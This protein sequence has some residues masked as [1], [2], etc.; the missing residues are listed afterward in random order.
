MNCAGWVGQLTTDRAYDTYAI[1]G[2]LGSGKTTG[3]GVAFFARVLTNP[4]VKQFWV[5]AP[6]YAKVDDT[7]LPTACFVLSNWFGLKLD[8]HFKIR[9]TKPACLTILAT[10]QEI[11]FHSGDRPYA[12]VSATIGGYWISE[13]GIQ[14]RAVFE[15]C[16]DRARDKKIDKVFGFIEGTPEGSN[17]YSDEFNIEGTDE[18]K[19]Y[20][21]FIIK[22]YDNIK[23]LAD[24]YIERLKR[25][26]SYSPAKILSYLYGQFANFTTGNV[27]AQYNESKNVLNEDY[28]PSPMRCVDLCFDFNATPLC[29][30]CWQ[31]T[32]VFI[33]GNAVFQDV[34]FMENDLN[35]S[36]LKDAVVDFAAHL[37]AY[38]KQFK[39]SEIRVF[40][41][42]TGHAASH[43]I[44]GSD[45]DNIRKYLNE[46]FPNVTIK[47]ARELTPIRASVDVCNKLFLYERL[48]I[49]SV[50]KNVRRSFSNSAWKP[51]TDDIEKKQGETITHHAD[52]ARYR[53]Y[54]LY[55]DF[56][57]NDIYNSS[58]KILT[59]G[60]N[61]L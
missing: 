46:I 17:W 44:R 47:A 6:T 27:F 33:A 59:Q 48:Q 36:N 14:T 26:Y 30:S 58:A 60:F 8:K 39:Y 5:V 20:R 24:G 7:M 61:N 11:Y 55:K 10:G 37:L 2:G 35:C 42:R 29:W 28:E 43:K 23:N 45:F 38:N 1:T 25:T 15:K 57:F 54:Q 56:D 50:C 49:N 12:M 18:D 31:T 19:S 34:C 4:K 53:I 41:D 51:G 40:G 22:T 32:K 16:V 3:V 52:G 13:P 9:K 21:R